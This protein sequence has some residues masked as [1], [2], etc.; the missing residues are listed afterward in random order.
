MMPKKA[1]I[2]SISLFIPFVEWDYE[3]ED[4]IPSANPYWHTLTASFEKIHTKI[5]QLVR[6]LYQRDNNEYYIFLADSGGMIC[7]HDINS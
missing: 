6:F 4:P 2:K 7:N 5:V 3:D 1:M